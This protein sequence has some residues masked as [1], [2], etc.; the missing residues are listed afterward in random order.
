V[1]RVP[2]DK[3]D[4]VTGWH[5]VYEGY[6]PDEE[7]LREALCT[8]GNGYLATRGA[9]PEQVAGSCHYPGTYVA[10]LFNR[11]TSRVAGRD[12]DNES[13]VNVPNWLPL[14]FRIDGGTWFDID[15]VELLE[16]EQVLDLRR[17]VLT[18]RFRCRDE[19]GCTSAVTQRRLTHMQLRNVC[20]LETTIRAEDWSGLLEVRSGLDG[21][22]ENTLVER[23]RDLDGNHLAPLRATE[24]SND[25]VLLEVM[26]NQSNVRV[27]LAARTT[28]HVAGDPLGVEREVVER[29]GWI[30]H[31]LRLDVRCGDSVT[32]DK[33]VTVFTGRDPAVTEPAEEAVRWLG[34]LGTFEELLGGHVMVWRHLWDRFH[35]ELDDERT[36]TIVRLH[37][38]HVLQTLSPNT[39]DLDAGV[40]ARGLHGE[41][42]RGHILWDEIFVLPLLNLRLPA[43][44]RSLLLY[45]YRRLPEAREAA[46]AAGF[47]GAMFPWQSGSDG[48]EENQRF[49]LNPASGRW[50][51]DTT[52]R[53]RHI[54]LAV[55]YNVWQYLQVTDDRQFLDHYGAEMLVD[56]AC[57]FS[58]ITE[59]DPARDRY[60]ISGVMGPDE[61]HS[62]YPDEGENGL[63]NNAYTNIM[64]VWVLGRA[65]DALDRLAPHDRIE[66][67][68]R[69]GLGASDLDRWQD[70]TD[71][72]FVPFHS[73][74]VLSQFEGYDDL[75]ELDWDGYRQRYG[76]IQRLDRILEAEGDHVNRYKASK[77]A[78]ALML[79]YLLSVDELREL[80]ERLGYRLDPDTVRRTI[81]Y[82]LAR[83]SHGSTLSAVVHSWVLTRAQ[84]HGGVDLFF[85]ALHSDVVDIQGGTTHEGIH[86]AAMA[87]SVDLL[88]RCFAGVE[89][90]EDRLILNPFWP[91]ELGTLEFNL[92][93][94]DHLLTVQ[95]DG[96][97]VRLSTGAGEPPAIEVS[98]RG[99]NA[100]LEPGGSLKFPL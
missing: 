14:T 26:T 73:D 52:D 53:Q 74:G 54:G 62:G 99:E 27:A 33:V 98:C 40:P 90:R 35:V 92:R 44:S 15:D 19:R 67:L 58:S 82:Y 30:G 88:Q 100:V 31:D 29:D 8:V 70:I 80:L 22:V 42:Y 11:R 47:S 89:T 3:G 45:R 94:R 68:E 9:A 43:L 77:Q 28:A 87:G 10:G 56:I 37:L 71:K 51:A 91:E 60:G 81:D 25:S 23:Y 49:H 69:L 2:D 46:R 18:R 21:T 78:D 20:A 55:A 64:T 12:I 34:R 86:L 32:V 1:E 16:Y 96:D 6:D 76:D 4:R 63:R 83:T 50:I 5:W 65:L 39:V 38:M 13:M 36:M 79:F 24:V 85:H 7:L 17:G 93:Y 66:L 72:M 75:E 48:R 57:F 84:R 59:Y 95:V 41:A 61:F 97:G